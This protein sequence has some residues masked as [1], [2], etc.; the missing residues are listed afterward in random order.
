MTNRKSL[1]PRK[2]VLRTMDGEWRVCQQCLVK[3]ARVQVLQRFLCNRCGN[4]ERERLA[5]LSQ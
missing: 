1:A 3:W 2:P 5:E 4:L